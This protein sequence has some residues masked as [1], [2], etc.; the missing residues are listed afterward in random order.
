MVMVVV[1]V[2]VCAW[3]VNDGGGVCV[4]VVAR[5][6]KEVVAVATL[7]GGGYSCVQGEG[8]SECVHECVSA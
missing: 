8:V 5:V 4:V 3:C 2:G 7:R 1:V 6:H